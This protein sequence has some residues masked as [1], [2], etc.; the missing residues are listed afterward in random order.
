MPQR[1]ELGGP[2]SPSSTFKT[3]GWA[4]D[5]CLRMVID[6]K[7]QMAIL[8]LCY[9]IFYMCVVFLNVKLLYFCGLYAAGLMAVR[10]HAIL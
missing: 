1:G 7:K 2:L 6:L 10:V 5:G 4:C 9:V 3:R 8:Y